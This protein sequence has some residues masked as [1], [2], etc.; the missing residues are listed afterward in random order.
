MTQFYHKNIFNLI[1]MVY[2]IYQ[3]SPITVNV[4]LFSTHEEAE[5]YQ[6]EV[7][8]DA[9]FARINKQKYFIK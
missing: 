4:G 6:K 7:Y 1:V 9:K 5:E 2:G 8:P 3:Y